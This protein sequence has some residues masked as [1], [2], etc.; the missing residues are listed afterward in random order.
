MTVTN[1]MALNVGTVCMIVF[2]VLGFL[3]AIIPWSDKVPSGIKVFITAT[4]IIA[5]LIVAPFST[6]YI[7][8]KNNSS[9]QSYNKMIDAINSNYTVVLD[10]NEIGPELAKEIALNVDETISKYDVYY[11]NENYKVIL[12]TK[13]V[14]YRDGNST[15]I[16]P[17]V[18]H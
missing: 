8:D 6:Q 5:G 17:M 10:G 15:V 4:L 13:P 2:T 7:I 14:R 18:V 3:L 16:V 11:D 9:G 1:D 12:V